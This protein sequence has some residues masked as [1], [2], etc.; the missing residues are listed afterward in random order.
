MKNLCLWDVSTRKYSI[1]ST[2][3]CASYGHHQES[4]AGEL[5]VCSCNLLVSNF[6]NSGEIKWTKDLTDLV[7]A[8]NA[9]V[10]IT[11]LSLANCVSVGLVNGELI[12]ISD[13]GSNCDL[14]GT[15]ENGLL[16]MEWSPDQE[17]LVLVTK[18]L[19][20][21]L[22]SYMYDPIN[23][24]NLINNEF[25]EKQ[26]ITVGWGKKE[27]QFH[28]SEGKQA[29][30]L[31][32][33]VFAGEDNELN[34]KIVITWRGDGTLF[35]VGF[36]MEGIRRFKVFDSDGNLQYT[37]E[38][39]PGLEANLSWRPSGN[40]IATTQRL[41]DKYQIAFFEKNGLKHGEFTIPV[42]ET[43][44][45]EDLHWSFDSEILALLCRDTSTNTQ[46]VLLFTSS[47][48]HWYLKQT[49]FFN[50]G[51]AINTILWD[52][53]FDIAN[54]KKLHIVLQNGEHYIYTW[55][56]GTDH[57]KGRSDCDDAVVV[58]IDG[59]KL[60]VS[61]FRY[62]TVP[63]PMA[64]VEIELDY[65]IESVHFAPQNDT[66]LNSNSFMVKTNKQ[67]IFL[68][69]SLR[70]P[71][72]YEVSE[73][74]ACDNVSFPFKCYNWYWL[75]DKT[76]LC[77]SVDNDGSYHLVQYSKYDGKIIQES[78]QPLPSS[79]TRIQCHPSLP[80]VAFL[81][82]TT[83]EIIEYSSEGTITPQIYCFSEA[84]PKFHV[85]HVD[86]VVYF[87]GLSHKGCL[88]MND[89]IVLNN[90]SSISVHTSFLLLTT[91]K[92]ILLCIELT[93]SGLNCIEKYE[94]VDNSDVYKR[95]IER[96]AKLV[97]TVPNGTRTVLQMPRGN[98]ETI[99]PRPLS[100]KIIGEY[101]NHCKYHDAFD[102][103]RK[104]RINLNLI[105]DHNPKLFTESIPV[106]LDNIQNNSWLNL[107]LSDLENIDVTKT[108]YSSC[109]PE[110]K[111]NVGTAQGKIYNV[112]DIFITHINKADDYAYRIL[113][114][115][116]AL[117]KK[118][119]LE[120]ALAIINNLKK[121]ELNKV[122][123][124]VSSDEALKYLLY[125]V[126]V[127][128]L[129]DV[130][131][132]MYDFD[133]VLLVANKSQ[134]DPKEYVAM[135]NELS[136]MDENYKQFTINK[137]LKRFEKA[138]QC[139]ARC[140]PNRHD[141][142]KTFVKYHS[143]YREALALFSVNE[144]IY[145][146]MADDF[147]H[148]LKL[149]KLH[150]EAGIIY[151][152][153]NCYDKAVE[154]YKDALEWE[155]VLKLAQDKPKE[156]FKEICWDLANALKEEKRHKEALK[157]IEQLDDEEDIIN[158]AIECG[159]FKAALRFCTKFNRPQLLDETLLPSLV[160]EFANTKELIETNSANFDKYRSRLQIVRDTK[161]NKPVEQY[162][163]ICHIVRQVYG[164]KDSD[165]YSDAG[166]TVASSSGSGRTYR[167]SKN[168][169]KH[170][171]KVASLKEGS[172]YEDTALVM[173]LHTLIVST[174]ELRIQV[175]EI[176]IVLS[177]LGKDSDALSLQLSL[178]KT[179]KV[180]KESFKEIWSNEFTLEATNAA[181]AAENVPDGCSV[182]P[183][184]MAT[185]DSHLRIAP[186]V[187]DIQ[188]KLEGL[189]L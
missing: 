5:F 183:Q 29:A 147:G 132:G 180:M 107:F 53:D 22:M 120:K 160:E 52:N 182:I 94:K 129:F 88:Y 87:L 138:V 60:L 43:T 156:E 109:Y 25:G 146:Q 157:I 9:P 82:L 39:Q 19:N 40:L 181:I 38:K 128:N 8:E 81:Q 31:K 174:F 91:L 26:F 125:M 44:V 186:V 32:T 153:A 101:L 59:K 171:R 150:I 99:E 164:N 84:C 85:L 56:W 90:V 179:L 11:Y 162:D 51:Q 71:L 79:V 126:N 102:L 65:D 148:Y 110:R 122:D 167:S 74:V 158:F 4:S 114:L 117:V 159:Q 100:L 168:R 127:D 134:K 24:S 78:S 3:F 96:G 172:Q 175:K 76:F 16:A 58:V 27:T 108:M 97:V 67:F 21:I 141:E 66:D 140:G 93:K 104:Q 35:A 20:V 17:L 112:C 176:N 106:F 161:R 177:C 73:T 95:K 28:G 7:S 41:P 131:L 77:T 152:R 142:L 118:N 119:D 145:K 154:C 165:L 166:S 188:W 70:N 173:V 178:E 62:T 69:Q 1:G 75:E 185:L 92:H 37:S 121:E 124:P 133:L 151:E 155:L 33:E 68:E 187:Q 36:V 80:S 57:S 54:N 61:A 49:L 48:Y 55:I 189:N 135:L 116:T 123:I 136:E 46:K 18:D 89:K 115:L 13:L 113:P 163:N 34:N 15:C 184:G 103:M 23:E 14:A 12:T 10:N 86:G 45:V 149:K 144:D 170:E 169:R 105:Y 47:N 137:H 111:N 130:A 30:K 139:L 63:P 83:G 50:E 2:N 98:L 42:E 64:N 6:D 72:R 143:L